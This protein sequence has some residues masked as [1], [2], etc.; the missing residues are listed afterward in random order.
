MDLKEGRRKFDENKTKE[1]QLNK[2]KLTEKK[3]EK[4]KQ[5]KICPI[6]T[7]I[8]IILFLFFILPFFHAWANSLTIKLHF[9]N[10]FLC[11]VYSLIWLVFSISTY[12]LVKN[13]DKENKA[14]ETEKKKEDKNISNRILIIIYLVVLIVGIVFMNVITCDESGKMKFNPDNFFVNFRDFF[15]GSG[16]DRE[17]ESYTGLP[18]IKELPEHPEDV[19]YV[20]R[21]EGCG[22]DWVY[23]NRTC[24]EFA[25]LNNYTY[26]REPVEGYENC[27]NLAFNFCGAPPFALEDSISPNRIGKEG[28]HIRCGNCCVWSC[29]EE[30][31]SCE[32]YA[33]SLGYENWIMLGEEEKCREIAE[34]KC[35]YGV[36][37]YGEKESCCVWKCKENETICVDNDGDHFWVGGE[38]LRDV[39][40]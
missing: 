32:E 11:V 37:T 21:S 33:F 6:L 36:E 16:E 27:W 20:N 24:E 15:G 13:K 2:L 8:P 29:Y 40:V 35:D 9:C 26:W 22:G 31:F 12:Y 5:T 23:I 28:E 10:H 25:R 14:E 19:S 17:T 38:E 18:E 4:K 1:R 3:K 34:Q 39:M 30:N 7:I